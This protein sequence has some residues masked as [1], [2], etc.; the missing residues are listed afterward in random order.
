MTSDY[1]S[2]FGTHG[3]LSVDA[4]AYGN[5]SRFLNDYRNT[6]R[7]PNVEFKLRRDARGELRQGVYVKLKKESRDPNFVGVACG[8]ELLVSY[9]RS[10]WRSRVGNLTEFV[11]RLPGMSMP[12]EGGR[13]SIGGERNTEEESMK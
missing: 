3:E 6:G 11:W 9:G 8:E 10:Y 7:Y 13:R 4:S 2:D 1:L 12:V 5:E